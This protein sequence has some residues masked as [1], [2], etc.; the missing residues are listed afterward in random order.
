[1]VF[2]HCEVPGANPADGTLYL[3]QICLTTDPGGGKRMMLVLA[4]EFDP[5]P[6]DIT[7]G[8]H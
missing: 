7:I 3:K 4:D 6:V 5:E 8:E 1:L 2:H